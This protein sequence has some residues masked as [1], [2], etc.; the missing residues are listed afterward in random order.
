MQITDIHVS[1][2]NNFSISGPLQSFCKDVIGSVNPSLIIVSGDLTHA[3]FADERK[4]QQFSAEWKAYYNA[5]QKCS[6]GQIPWLDIRGNH[7]TFI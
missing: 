7:G 5:V 1:F 6:L 3:K 4:S 2:V